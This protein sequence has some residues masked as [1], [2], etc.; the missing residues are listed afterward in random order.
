MLQRAWKAA[1]SVRLTLWLLMLAVLFFVIGSVYLRLEKEVLPLLNFQLLPGWIARHGLARIG[2][3]WWLFALL[4][5]LL[6]L[7]INTFA[8]SIDRLLRLLPQRRHM[9]GSEFAVAVTPTL[10]HL[11]FLL[12]LGGHLLSSAAGSVETVSCAPGRS[13]SLAGGRALEVLAVRYDTH[14]APPALAGKLKGMS[15]KL[16]YRAPGV[17]ER[18]TA[19]VLAP[20]RRG[21]YRFYLDAVDKYARS[22]ELRLIV[23]RDPGIAIILP[24]LLAIILLMAWYFP[25]LWILRKRQDDKEN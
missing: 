13:A 4:L 1:A 5:T 7:G 17:D 20:A 15:A 23:R 10:V 19:A 3:S 25:A 8:C 21:G 14:H 2:L 24:G 18:F 9:S 6:L 11:V 12:V 16:H 22:R